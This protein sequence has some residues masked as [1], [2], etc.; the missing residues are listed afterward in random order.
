MQGGA[1]KPQNLFY[2]THT[3]F[4][5]PTHL[6]WS[7]MYQVWE[8]FVDGLVSR[9]GHKLRNPEGQK[10]KQ[11]TSRYTPSNFILTRHFPDTLLT[12]SSIH[13]TQSHEPRGISRVR[14]VRTADHALP[15][16]CNRKTRARRWRW[17]C[18][19]V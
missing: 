5:L 2:S 11:L 13:A 7:I 18:M 10:T 19:R 8:G 14:C 15:S 3:R 9:W 17:L 6:T 1:R 4:S 12:L 16:L